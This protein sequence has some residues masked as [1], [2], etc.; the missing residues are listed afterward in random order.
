M[1]TIKYIALILFLISCKKQEV[2]PV[3]ETKTYTISVKVTGAQ[4]RIVTL[5]GI[6]MNPPFQVKTGDVLMVDYR[7]QAST[8]ISYDVN[9]TIYQDGTII[10]SCYG[11][12]QYTKTFNIE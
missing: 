1:K 4:T 7:S 9:V 5:N 11:C 2:E 12:N 10:G 8:P 6:N 3:K